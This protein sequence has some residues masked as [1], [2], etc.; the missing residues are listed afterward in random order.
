M[1]PVLVV[2]ES[3][4]VVVTNKRSSSNIQTRSNTSTKFEFLDDI[5]NNMGTRAMH[6]LSVAKAE[7]GIDKPHEK[8][9]TDQIE[10]VN[11]SVVPENLKKLL[12]A[13]DAYNGIRGWQR[14]YIYY[15]L[16]PTNTVGPFD[17]N[18]KEHIVGFEMVG[19]GNMN[20]AKISDQS[21]DPSIL[22]TT[23]PGRSRVTYWT[24]G[25]FEFKVK[26][27]LGNK[28]A[29]G[30]ELTTHF[31][32]KPSEL[33]DVRF[34]T[35]QTDP[36]ALYITH[37]NNKKASFFLPLFQWDLDNYS[38]NIK[39][40]IEEVD[41][42]ETIKQTSST[43]TEYATNFG[44]SAEIGKT[45]KMGLEFGSTTKESRTTSYEVSTTYG[46]DE[47]GEVIINF[48]DKVITS[49]EVFGQTPGRRTR[50]VLTLDYNQGYSN[51]WYR[52]Y[53]APVKIIN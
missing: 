39:I 27:Y 17:D 2:K 3:E 14:D 42:S 31:R 30:N 44:Y 24:D 52:L 37:V 12:D 7:A 21:G 15:N 34:S 18:F 6:E 19:D 47:L 23:Q 33:F 25:E 40:A 11:T 26:V 35:G 49:R 20:V 51:G 22:S 5:F 4:R 8:M 9:G 41:A 45:V 13:Y 1:F 38:A 10:S 50:D 48:G 28:S 32:L 29:F 46:N 53:I 36:K 43:T 16:S